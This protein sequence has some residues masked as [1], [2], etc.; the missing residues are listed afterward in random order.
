MRAGDRTAPRRLLPHISPSPRRPANTSLA[1]TVAT[2]SPHH[3]LLSISESQVHRA[4]RLRACPIDWASASKSSAQM[5]AAQEGDDDGIEVDADDG[6]LEAGSSVCGMKARGHPRHV[7]RRVPSGSR[8]R[9]GTERLVGGSSGCG[10]D[11]ARPQEAARAR[12]RRSAARLFG[13]GLGR[14]PRTDRSTRYRSSSRRRGVALG[15]QVP[16]SPRGL[17]GRRS[18]DRENAVRPPRPRSRSWGTW[19]RDTV[20]FVSALASA[21][22][23]S[24][25]A[26]ASR[27]APL[28]YSFG[29]GCSPLSRASI[30]FGPK[31]G[32]RSTWAHRSVGICSSCSETYPRRG[33][34]AH[35][36]RSACA[37]E[38]STLKRQTQRRRMRGRLLLRVPPAIPST[39]SA[40][41]NPAAAGSRSLA[42]A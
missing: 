3:C 9:P 22:P 28:F 6:G 32:T 16:A 23:I 36:S 26:G 39:K 21:S 12:A 19:R 20:G 8:A 24:P 13:E 7:A 17:R 40:P 1:A 38:G 14:P 30:S 25:S 34:G 35:R 42:S 5:A 37:I 2:R 10:V 41:S 27:T 18:A 29:L 11:R 33:S 31:R 15:T 4:T